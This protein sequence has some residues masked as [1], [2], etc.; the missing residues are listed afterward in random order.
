MG[1]LRIKANQINYKQHDGQI[2]EE[3]IDRINDETM[4]TEI[5]KEQP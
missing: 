5:M 1:H 2:K 3:Y 4:M